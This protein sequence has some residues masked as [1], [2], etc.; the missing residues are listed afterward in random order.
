MK[1]YFILLAV[2]LGL[3]VSAQEGVSYWS[4]QSATGAVVMD[5]KFASGLSLQNPD[6]DGVMLM[7]V[8]SVSNGT[9]VLINVDGVN[10]WTD[11]KANSGGFT[12]LSWDIS[13][14]P[15]FNA[16]LRGSIIVVRGAMRNDQSIVCTLSGF[17]KAYNFIK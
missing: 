9:R 15:Y 6:G 10:Y 4:I 12:L 1:K 2:V 13:K 5:D 11:A 7:T 14:E 3:N 17:T 16:M 8:G